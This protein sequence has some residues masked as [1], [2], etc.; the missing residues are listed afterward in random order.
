MDRNSRCGL[1]P[2]AWG[3]AFWHVMYCVAANYNPHPTSR[4]KM[5]AVAFVHSI[6]HALPCRACRENFARHTRPGSPAALTEDVFA[7]RESFFSW[8]YA[9]HCE[10]SVSVKGHRPPFSLEDAWTRME[11][12][13]S[14][15]NDPDPHRPVA[16]C[17][18][19]FTTQP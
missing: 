15:C 4:D 12:I 7:S 19:S 17:A 9:L 10:V 1:Q 6:Y 11:S 5:R 18:L 8:I 2:S 13:R 14:R 16:R 3:P